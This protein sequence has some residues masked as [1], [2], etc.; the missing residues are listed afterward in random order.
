[1]LA[2][3]IAEQLQGLGARV[4]ESSAASGH[5]LCVWVEP[6]TEARQVLMWV[7]ALS[8]LSSSARADSEDVEWNPEWP[9]FR[10]SEALVS[11]VLGT[12]AL[13]ALLLYPA[14]EL[15]WRGANLFD[16][17][18][19]GAWRLRDRDARESARAVSDPLYYALAVYPFMVD[20]ALVTWGMH[21]SGDVALEMLAMNAESYALTGALAL[22]AQKLGRL[23]PAGLD[24]R[25]DPDYSPKCGDARALSESFFSGHTAVA[26]TSAGL[27]CAHHQHLPLYGGGAADVAACLVGLTAASAEGALRIATDDHYASDVL[28][29]AFV[30]LVS[31]YV[32]PSWLHY[33]FRN[34]DTKETT[35]WLPT[36]RS[37]LGGA[38]FAAI[39]TPELDPRYAGVT[40]V[41]AY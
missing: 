29:G 10:A 7:A 32:L 30:G 5:A 3:S 39:V 15:T 22:T 18:V 1:M 34:G 17:A 31:G 37:E 20:T 28:L 40:F 26:F 8:A 36:F 41:G 25:A 21:G 35:T 27:T 2:H 19:R 14:P 13:T 4:D 9:R 6:M 11:S 24:C 12:Q 23:R 38:P 33:G 16:D